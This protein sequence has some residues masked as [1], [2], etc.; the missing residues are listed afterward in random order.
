MIEPGARLILDVDKAAAGGRMLARHSGRVVLVSGAIP[1]ERVSARV[2]RLA[3]GVIYAD[4]I[5]VLAASPDRRD[6]PSDWRCGGNVFAHVNY[7]RQLALKADI[8]RDAFTRIGHLPLTTSPTMVGSHEE[9][10]RM[11]A[12]LHAQGGKLG[13]F[14]EGT[15]QLCEVSPTRQLLPETLAWIAGA[16]ETIARERLAGLAGLEIAENIAGDVRVCHLELH[17]G[18]DAAPFA[19]LALGL[20]GLSAER[21]DRAGVIQ[22]SGTPIIA[23]TVRVTDAAHAASV[24]FERDVRAFFQGNRYLLETLVRHVVSLL[25]SGPVVDLYAGVGWFGLSAVA[26]GWTD[27]TLVEGDAISGADLQRNALVAGAAAKVERRSVEAFL[28]SGTPQRGRRLANAT[29]SD[30]TFIIDPPRTGLTRDALTGI[31]DKRPARIVYVS[32][33]VATLA[34]DAR[35]LVDAGYSMG[36]VTGM[37]LFPNTAHVETIVAFGR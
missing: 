15:H 36:E 1:G 29:Q 19:S 3:K 9:G 24:V 18:T 27:V 26:A 2:E 21:T 17:G 35:V 8:I 32:C 31:V 28:R 10:Y 34:R 20:S 5:T 7:P 30:A 33:D 4:T 13:F 16:E 22:L 37:D 12:R 6:A 14:R 25:A 11:R 23:D